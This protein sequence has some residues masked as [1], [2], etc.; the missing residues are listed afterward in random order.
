MVNANIA[1]IRDTFK[2]A[3]KLTKNFKE[4]IPKIIEENPRVLLVFRILAKL[5]QEEAKKKI[6][7]SFGDYETGRIRKLRKKEKIARLFNFAKNVLEELE[8]QDIEKIF[9]TNL[10][11]LLFPQR[12]DNIKNKIRT[13]VIKRIREQNYFEVLKKSSKREKIREEE[14]FVANCLNARKILFHHWI[15][16]VNVDIF[17]PDEEVAI[18]ITKIN[19]KR[20]STRTILLERVS[21]RGLR[22]K[23]LFPQI[24]TVCIVFS[25]FP[26]TPHQEILLHDSFDKV[27]INPSKDEISPLATRWG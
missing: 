16:R 26:V 23:K 5:T 17:I 7:P 22:L 8:G 9:N 20:Y 21:L 1:R 3:Q 4:I 11:F 24:T 18:F 2:L 14:R 19:S 10:E 25:N 15:G 12:R 6:D 27:L 13:A